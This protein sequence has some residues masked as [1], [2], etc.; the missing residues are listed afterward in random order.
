MWANLVYFA[1]LANLG[2]YSLQLSLIVPHITARRADGRTDRD[3]HPSIPL[4]MWISNHSRLYLNGVTH[5]YCTR[6]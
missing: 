3:I 2:G 1:N 5:H 6:Y 4:I